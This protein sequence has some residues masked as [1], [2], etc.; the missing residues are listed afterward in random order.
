MLNDI[1]INPTI[2]FDTVGALYIS[3]WV[4]T[5]YLLDCPQRADLSLLRLSVSIFCPAS[6]DSLLE[7]TGFELLV[8]IAMARADP[9]GS[10]RC[11]SDGPRQPAIRR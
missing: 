2:S 6:L 7:G 3:G 5:S 9:G 11:L 10:K 8:P 4:L 1:R